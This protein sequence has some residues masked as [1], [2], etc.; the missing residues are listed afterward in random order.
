MDTESCIATDQLNIWFSHFHEEN[1][2]TIDG[3]QK[4]ALLRGAN[5]KKL[6]FVQDP[7]E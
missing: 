4:N 2:I 6:C 1:V 5:T 7:Y 3:G